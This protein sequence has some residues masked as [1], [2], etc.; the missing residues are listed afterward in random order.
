[1]KLGNR[2]RGAVALAAVVVAAASGCSTKAPESQLF[3]GAT[4]DVAQFFEIDFFHGS[5]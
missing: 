1:M 3:T 2:S 5:P 4:D